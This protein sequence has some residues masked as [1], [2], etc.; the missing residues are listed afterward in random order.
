MKIKV[1]VKTISGINILYA[2][3]K[4]RDMVLFNSLE[5]SYDVD[6]F[7][8]KVTDM[9]S[10]WPNELE[11][12]NILDGLEYRVTIKEK[13]K[14]TTYRFKNKFPEDIYRLKELI[15]DVSKAVRNDKWIW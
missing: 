12:K 15:E 9:I 10:D 1:S 6:R 4:R 8:Y 3:D 2:N 14:E 11:N 5:T 13:G 7:I